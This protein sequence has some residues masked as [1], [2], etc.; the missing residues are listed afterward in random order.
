[1]ANQVRLSDFQ[2]DMVRKLTHGLGLA[3]MRR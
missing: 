1:M 3:A 2:S